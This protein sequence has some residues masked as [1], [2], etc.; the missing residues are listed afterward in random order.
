MGRS[1]RRVVVT[2]MGMIT[3]VGFDAES[4]WRALCEGRSGVGP[5]RLFDASAFATRIAAEVTGFR[6][7]DYRPDAL[8]WRDHSRTTQFALAAGTLA[9]QQAGLEDG[10]FNRARFGVCLGSGEGEQDFGRF[11]KLV[12]ASTRDGR[13]GH[14]R[15]CRGWVLKFSTRLAKRTRSRVGPPVISRLSSEPAGRTSPVRRRA[16]PAPRPLARR[17][18]SSV[19][20]PST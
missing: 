16:P 13:V 3:P 5:V 6:L 4:S 18:S 11:V 12:H 1:G 14:S 19:A 8:R 2:G 20:E 15:G 17:A 7:A 9:V 10:T